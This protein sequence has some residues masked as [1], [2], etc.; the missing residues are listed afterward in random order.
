MAELMFGR[1][2]FCTRLLPGLALRQEEV[3]LEVKNAGGV[4]RNPALH[5]RDILF[6]GA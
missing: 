6:G 5:M 4:L 3:P 2:Q 1:L